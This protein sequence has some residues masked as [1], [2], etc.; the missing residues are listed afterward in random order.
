MSS[1]FPTRLALAALALLGIGAGAMYVKAGPGPAKAIAILKPK[2]A[3]RPTQADWPARVVTLAGDGV[4]GAADGAAAQARFADPFGVAVDA[5][6]NVYLAEGG[7]NNRIRKLSAKGIVSTLAGAREGFADGVGAAA[8]FHTP[9]GIALDGAGNVYVADTGNNA[10][11]KVAPD[12]TVTTLAGGGGAGFRDGKGGA[13]Q[14]DGPL[15]VAMGPDGALYVADAYNDRIRRVAPDGEVSTVAGA[16]RPG[17]RDGAALDAQFDTPC[18]LV[19]D[20]QGQ[21]YIADAQNHAIRKLGSDG[22]V[23][24]LAR[25]TPGER[26][27]LPRRPMGLALTHDGFLYISSGGGRVLQLAPDGQLRALGDAE[28]P[29]AIGS[30]DGTVRLGQPRG[31]ALARDGALLVADAATS[32]LRRLEPAGP[33]AV[34]PEL[35]ALAP[36]ALRA[37]VPRPAG[38]MLWPLKPQ[39]RA[40]EVVGVMGEV[41]GNFDGE[42]RD[43]FHSGLDIQAAVGAPVLAIAAGKVGNPLPNWGYGELSEGFSIEGISYIHMRV[44]RGPNDLPLDPR[45]QLLGDAA[46]K[47]ERVRIRRGARFQVGDALGSVNR[48]AHVHLDYRQDGDEINPLSLSFAGQR[49]TVAPR[50]EGIALFDAAGLALAPKRGARLRLPRALGEVRIV[51]DAY[52]QMD[53][54]QARRR[55]GLYKLGYQLLRAD[56][57]P[58]PGFEQPVVTQVYDRLPAARDAVKLAYAPSSGITVHGSARTRFLYDL[59]NTLSDGQASPGAWRI[60][61]LAPGD[62]VLRILA[63]DY[64]GNVALAGRDLRLTID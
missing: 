61:A 40:H 8:A 42:S 10:I 27:S 51:V 7:D 41:R 57:R 45:F 5:A 59:N 35:P 37:P 15:G 34:A 53:G 52:D 2:P 32:Q 54:N 46:G 47:P 62:Y 49:D 20:A 4:A 25:A 11:R 48:M 39:G 58:A 18:A 50:I 16:G 36:P 17:A 38:A 1:T 24:T 28:R 3:P 12:G 31:I 23:T 64:A 6:G 19:L 63:A 55:L 33:A 43:H 56:G 21:I 22:Q 29:A 9:S 26:D 14:F 13:A 60:A 44:G 30:G